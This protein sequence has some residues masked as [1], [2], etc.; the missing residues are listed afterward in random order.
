[1]SLPRRDVARTK[2][3]PRESSIVHG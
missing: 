2:N 1:M 3:R